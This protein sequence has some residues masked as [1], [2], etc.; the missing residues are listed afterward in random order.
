[1]FCQLPHVA[2]RRVSVPLYF[3]VRLLPRIYVS[4]DL[5]D[6]VL[7]YGFCFQLCRSVSVLLKTLCFQIVALPRFCSSV[8]TWGYHI[9]AVSRE[10][11]QDLC[12][13]ITT[14]FTR[15]YTTLYGHVGCCMSL[16]YVDSTTICSL[17]S[18]VQPMA[19]W[20]HQ[21]RSLQ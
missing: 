16:L 17:C 6:H 11:V 15:T 1:M 19:V 4:N 5:V 18:Q 12:S 21:F 9:H 14:V 2:C 13:S 10:G 8:L 20:I 7:L 3:I